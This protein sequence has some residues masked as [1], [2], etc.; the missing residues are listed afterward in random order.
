MTP[1]KISK[2]KKAIL[3]SRRQMPP[4]RYMRMSR[5]TFQ[6]KIPTADIKPLSLKNA[7]SLDMRRQ[8][9][10]GVKAHLGIVKDCSR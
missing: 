3:G 5:Y 2:I 4:S 6:M 9:H 8:K 10:L 1:R 7:L